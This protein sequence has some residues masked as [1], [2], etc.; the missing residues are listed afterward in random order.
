MEEPGLFRDNKE[1]MMDQLLN[2]S[3]VTGVDW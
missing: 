3:W 1:D 2:G